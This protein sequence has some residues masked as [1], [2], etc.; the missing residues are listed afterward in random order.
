[1]TELVEEHCDNTRQVWGQYSWECIAKQVTSSNNHREL[2]C[3]RVSAFNQTQSWPPTT[4]GEDAEPDTIG[5]AVTF[6]VPCISLSSRI[7]N[8]AVSSNPAILRGRSE[9]SSRN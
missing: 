7:C 5:E 2:T 6:F 9:I 4:V 8:R 3:I 1:M